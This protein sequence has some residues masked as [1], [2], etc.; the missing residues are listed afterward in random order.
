MKQNCSIKNTKTPSPTKA[1]RSG[2]PKLSP[3]RPS[4]K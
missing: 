3:R 1:K 2:Y 4:K